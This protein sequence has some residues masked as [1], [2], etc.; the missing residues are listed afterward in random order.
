MR[1]HAVQAVS[2]EYTVPLRAR[3]WDGVFPENCVRL[4]GVRRCDADDVLPSKIVED[5]AK[6][7]GASIGVARSMLV[8]VCSLLVLGLAIVVAAS[9]VLLTRDLEARHTQ[10]V[11]IPSDRRSDVLLG[12]LVEEPAATAFRRARAV[13]QTGD[14]FAIVVAANTDRSTAGMLRLV[15][16]HY[17]FPAIA[18]AN[19][20]AAHVVVVLGART[21]PL[22]RRFVPLLAV[23]GA[24]VGVRR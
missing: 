3:D 12:T 6:I 24:W 22:P 2:S 8:Q 10:R 9:G 20:A 18:V 7:T 17:L 5:R 15:S 4:R 1:S 11:L 19:P 23:T 21:G 13:L 14:R 16:Q